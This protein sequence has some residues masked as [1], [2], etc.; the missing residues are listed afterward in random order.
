MHTRPSNLDR[1]N[2]M[3]RGVRETYDNNSTS[4]QSEIAELRAAVKE[5]GE[6]MTRVLNQLTRQS[7]RVRALEGATRNGSK[8][9]VSSSRREEAAKSVASRNLNS[10]T[11]CR[12][13]NKRRRDF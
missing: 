11:L 1:E 12:F 8:A 2:K 5:Q 6:S 10:S 4:L 7:S 3:F 9:K 13:H